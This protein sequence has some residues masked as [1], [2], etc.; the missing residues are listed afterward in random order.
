MILII[1]GHIRD[2]FK[3]RDLYHLIKELHIKFPDIKIF[4]HTWNIINNGIS[5]RKLNVNH[6]CVND[7]IISMI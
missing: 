6:Q 7:D 4:I 1:R 5:W 3:T 2:S